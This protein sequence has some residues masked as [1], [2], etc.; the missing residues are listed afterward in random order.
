MTFLLVALDSLAV[1]GR[2]WR[3][4]NGVLKVGGPAGWSLNLYGRLLGQSKI[5]P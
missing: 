3:A 4:V 2:L 1:G 5:D